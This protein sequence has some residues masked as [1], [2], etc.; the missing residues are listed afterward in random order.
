[1]SEFSR[2]AVA[3]TALL[4]ITL[5]MAACGRA[6]AEELS[7]VSDKTRIEYD[8]VG[9]VIGNSESYQ[10]CLDGTAYDPEVFRGASSSLSREGSILVVTPANDGV[11]LR[12]TNE[13][14]DRPL[15]PADEASQ[16][17]LQAYGCDT[18]PYDQ[19][20]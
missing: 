3:V 13:G 15:Q 17:I 7:G 6:S 14:N 10:D 4:S 8:Y 19:H 20:K 2:R 9:G 12:L 5:G 1:M 11:G 18:G 16:L